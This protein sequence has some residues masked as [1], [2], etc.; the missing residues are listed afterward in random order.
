MRLYLFEDSESRSYNLI[1]E[2]IDIDGSLRSLHHMLRPKL[3]SLLVALTNVFLH[4]ILIRYRRLT[5]FIIGQRGLWMQELAPIA[6]WTE[7]CLVKMLARLCFEVLGQISFTNQLMMSM[8]KGA[9]INPL[10]LTSEL[11]R[12]AHLCF[13]FRLVCAH[14][15]VPLTFRC[16]DFLWT[17]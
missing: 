15:L 12:L 5:Y 10:A 7:S 3:I 9:S 13:E 17:F 11:P 2:F 6:I 16:K 14:E 8:R 4:N 1:R